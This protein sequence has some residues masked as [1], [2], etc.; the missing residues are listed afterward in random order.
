MDTQRTVI[1]NIL[2]YAEDIDK[3]QIMVNILMEN[4]EN[5]FVCKIIWTY[6]C[7]I[8]ANHFCNFRKLLNFKEL[9]KFKS[10]HQQYILGSIL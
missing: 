6:R 9:L 5:I 7:K 2:D 4:E 3:Y 1:K 10:F 8:Y